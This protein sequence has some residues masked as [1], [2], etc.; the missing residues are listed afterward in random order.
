MKLEL[1]YIVGGTIDGI[2]HAADMIWVALTPPDNMEWL[3]K[4]AT[5][6]F[7]LQS[8]TSIFIDSEPITGTWDLRCEDGSC[9]RFEECI[10][11]LLQRETLYVVDRVFVDEQLNLTLQFT[12][13]LL[14]KTTENSPCATDVERWRILIKDQNSMLPHIMG[15]GD[16]IEIV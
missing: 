13:G 6:D 12:N 11:L 9:F 2:G 14:I 8:D 3:P 10:Q 15:M 4:T 1:E 5:I 7:H 16:H